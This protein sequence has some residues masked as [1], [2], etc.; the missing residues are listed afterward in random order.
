[1]PPEYAKD[2]MRGKR[3]IIHWLATSIDFMI[4]KHFSLSFGR[5][6]YGLRA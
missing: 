2:L 5:C 4:A 1:M 3:F 6:Y